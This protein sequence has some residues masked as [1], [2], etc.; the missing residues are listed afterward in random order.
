MTR[1]DDAMTFELTEEQ[2]MIQETAR[3]FA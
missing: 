1:G 2:R 3:N